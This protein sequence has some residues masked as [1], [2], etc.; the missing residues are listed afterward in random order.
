MHVLL[1]GA[2]GLGLGGRADVALGHEHAREII[3]GRQEPQ[4]HQHHERPE[5][6][7]G[8]RDRAEDA[9]Q[10]VDRQLLAATRA[11]GVRERGSGR[12]PWR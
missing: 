4:A 5:Q 2:R 6:R 11:G 12:Q 8:G 9:A 7:A 1:D 3:C 10:T